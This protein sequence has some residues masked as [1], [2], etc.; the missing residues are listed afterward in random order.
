MIN[1]YLS[2]LL[3]LA[4]S[5]L[6]ASA[7][8]Q[9]EWLE[10]SHDFG[11]FSEDLGQVSTEFRLV[12]TGDAP[13]RIIN[14]RATCGCTV[15]EYSNSDVAPGDTIA[16]AVSYNANG[17]PGRFDKKIYVTTSA[18]PQ[19]QSMLTIEGVVIGATHTLRS[20]YPYDAGSL[21]LRNDQVNF[22]EVK[23]GKVKTVFIEAY[24]QSADTVVPQ[25][26]GLPERVTAQVRP[27]AVPPGEQVS[28]TFSLNTLKSGLEWGINEESFALLNGSQPIDTL[29][30]FTLLSEDFSSLTPGQRLNAPVVEVDPKRA[31]LGKIAASAVQTVKF[32]ITNTGNNPLEVR[33]VQ[34]DDPALTSIKLSSDKIKKGKKAEITVILDPSLAAND[35]INVRLSVISN[36][37]N[38]SLTVVR[39]TAEL[40]ANL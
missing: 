20:R 25:F 30:W 38:E 32:T 7:Q 12:N 27:A 15:P 39:V 17:R 36:D 40:L 37:P 13:L 2:L 26:A 3:G 19:Q 18:D 28:F 6:G 1:R 31:D 5:T 33:R 22:G 9:I 21:K 24:N 10:K 11:V 34:C 23:R 16:V 8:A 4:M 35:F 14:A 29:R